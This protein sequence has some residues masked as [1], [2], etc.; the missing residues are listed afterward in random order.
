[1]A[2]LFFID[3]AVTNCASRRKHAKPWLNHITYYCDNFETGLIGANLSSTK[4]PRNRAKNGNNGRLM[5][6]SCGRRLAQAT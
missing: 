5:S 4:A 6:E 1:V 2:R 3:M